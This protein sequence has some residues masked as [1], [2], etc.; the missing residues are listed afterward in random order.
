MPT[1]DTIVYQFARLPRD[2]TQIVLKYTRVQDWLMDATATLQKGLNRTT[3]RKSQRQL[4]DLFGKL[5]PMQ[6]N[7]ASDERDALQDILLYA[8][9]GIPWGE[10]SDLDLVFILNQSIDLHNFFCF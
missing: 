6:T 8:S 10:W 5:L 3:V 9:R 2:L 1:A 7:V 4:Q